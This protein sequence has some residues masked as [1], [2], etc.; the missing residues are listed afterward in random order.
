MQWKPSNSTE[1]KRLERAFA[2]RNIPVAT[3][4]F[5]DHANFLKAE[6]GDPRFLELYARYVEARDYD[7]AYLATAATRIEIAA[8]AIEAAITADGRLGACVD[9]SGMLGRILDQLGVWNYVAKATLTIDF[10]PDSGLTRRHFW[11][12]DEGQF[13]AAHAIVVAPPYGIVD[14]TVRRQDYDEEQ[15]P[16]LP[17]TVLAADWKSASWTAEDLANTSIRAALSARGITFQKYLERSDPDVLE[18]MRVLPPREAS[19]GNTRL[20]YIIV[21][22][23][24]TIEPLEG[25]TGYK[26]CGR[27]AA[28]IFEEDIR[29]KIATSTSRQ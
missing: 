23:G 11:V 17:K 4:G 3:P 26:P 12:F 25:I 13:T 14:V 19:F 16:F 2:N 8:G 18:V 9:A 24:G 28:Q 15:L 1:R 6:R 5:F 10:P 22:V 27:T 21:A 20:K 29:P 7:D